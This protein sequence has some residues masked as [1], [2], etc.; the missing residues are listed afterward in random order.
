[1][2]GYNTEQDYYGWWQGEYIFFAS[3][4]DYR[5]AVEEE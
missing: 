2:K 5:D 1:M 3:E 4:A